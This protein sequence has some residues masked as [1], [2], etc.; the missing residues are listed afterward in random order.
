MNHEYFN[1]SPYPK[2]PDMMPTFPS[3][4]GSTDSASTLN[5]ANGAGN[6]DLQSTTTNNNNSNKMKVQKNDKS[7]SNNKMNPDHT[8][9]TLRKEG[10]ESNTHENDILASNYVTNVKFDNKLLDN[11]SISMNVV[12]S[13]DNIH[14]NRTVATKHTYGYDEDVMGTENQPKRMKSEL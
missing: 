10:A 4:H 1:S 6:R 11:E 5:I 3:R 14:D 9:P 13:T 7:N 2:E 12:H 8:Y